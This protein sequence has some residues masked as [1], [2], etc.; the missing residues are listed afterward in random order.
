MTSK[1]E[2]LPI[3]L[4]FKLEFLVDPPVKHNSYTPQNSYIP[5]FP[6]EF[7]SAIDLEIQKLLAKGVITKCEHET[8]EYISPI[9]IRQTPDT[10]YRLILNLKNLVEY[11]PYI[12]FKMATL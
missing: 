7:E 2:I 10:S 6:E 1:K 3:G 9:F 12:H 11:R 4:G 8:G 5:Q